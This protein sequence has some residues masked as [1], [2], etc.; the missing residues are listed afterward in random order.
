[1]K[2]RKAPKLVV[3]E[4]VS[5]EIDYDKLAAAIVAANTRSCS[6]KKKRSPV[7]MYLMGMCNGFLYVSLGLFA[8][9]LGIEMWKEYFATGIPSVFIC[10]CVSSLLVTWI[11]LFFLALQETFSDNENEVLSHFN[12][13]VSLVALVVALVALLKGGA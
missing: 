10:I 11:F 1:M 13:T 3:P 5:L 6:T 9:L 8:I 4:K 12:T 7:R 2:K